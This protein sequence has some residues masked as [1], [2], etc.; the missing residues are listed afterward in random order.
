[1]WFFLTIFLT[2]FFSDRIVK[3]LI[4]DNFAF[5][6]SYPVLEN[7]IHITPTY[8]T[9]IA[10]GLLRGFNNLVFVFLTVFILII[11]ASA[12]IIKKPVSRLL[13]AGFFF[14]IAGASGNLADRLLYG[15]V[16]DF[17][18]LRIWPVFNIADSAIC[19]G[20]CLIGLYI[21]KGDKQRKVKS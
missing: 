16:L 11:M 9:G 2:I 20:A 7:I 6:V 8:N 13:T 21:V 4:H 5:G 19:F 10:F 17:I 14:I 3:I 12:V 15:Y 18:D 1:V